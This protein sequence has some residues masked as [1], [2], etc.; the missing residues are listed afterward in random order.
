L[1]LA[2]S[3]RLS[4]QSA[5]TLQAGVERN[6]SLRAGLANASTSTRALSGSWTL[7]MP[8]RAAL[9]VT[10]RRVLS[11]STAEDHNESALAASLVKSF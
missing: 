1:S 11:D 9:S 2:V 4:P 5:L 8:Q 6:Q 10:A 3:H 7:Q